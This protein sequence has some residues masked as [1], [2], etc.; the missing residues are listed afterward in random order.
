MSNTNTSPSTG[1]IVS[2][3]AAGAA[4]TPS[5]ALTHTHNSPSQSS[6]TT[7]T[8]IAPPQKS[9]DLAKQKDSFSTPVDPE[10]GL[11]TGEVEKT[12]E[13]ILAQVVETLPLRQLAPA[14]LGVAMTMFMAAL[15]N[16][17]VS[18]ALPK[19][20]TQFSASNK[21]ELVFTCYVITFNAFQGLYG[22]MSNV[23]GRKPTVFFAITIFCT[24]SVLSGVSASMNMFLGARALTG[25]GAGGIFSLSNIIIADLVS[26]RDRGKYQGFISAVFAISALVGPVMGGAFVDKVS[27]RWCFFIQ[28]AL[29]VITVPTLAVMLKLPRPKGDIWSKIKAIDWAGTFFMAITAVFL[30]L[31]TNLGGNLYPWNSPL[32][33]TLYALAIPSIVMFLLVEAKHAENPIV[34]PYLWKN[35]NVVTLLSI[36]VFMGMTFWTLMFYLPIYFQI[37][38]HESATNAGLTMI[39]LEAGVF[40]SSNIAGLLV[41][42]YGKYRPYIF[43]GTGI[44]VVGICL[45]LVLAET[46]SKVIH[47]VILFVCGLGVGQL[48]PTLIVAIQASVERKDL[49]TVSALHNFFRMTGSGFGVAINGALFQNN[50]DS[51]LKTSGVPSEWAD[52]AKN[53]AQKIVDI[54]ETYRGMVEDVYLDSM[55]TVFRATI[56]MAVMMFLLTFLIR[57]VR[58]NAKAGP[59][60]P[61]PEKVDAAASETEGEKGMKEEVVEMEEE[62]KS[63]SAP[64]AV[65][66]DKEELK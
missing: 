51:G 4:G 52:L 7:I 64:S 44:A 58:L 49:A 55:K 50:L 25:I 48:F 39:P 19:I 47:V 53:S 29:A 2:S 33:I 40:I 8:V 28:I 24:G 31:P 14:F 9:D 12:S 5:N 41:S 6:T 17:I 26:I 37:I 35:H 30:L 32:I 66:G 22:K 23:F 18:T 56:P 61:E 38:E 34:P 60:T 10:S 46:S 27:W 11:P 45:C 1:E 62:K 20:G 36:N 13:E 15:D 16:S 43:T 54:P 65:R 21:V 63:A 57:H 42:K 59:S 3:A